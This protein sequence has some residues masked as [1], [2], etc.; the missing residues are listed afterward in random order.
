[1]QHI[2]SPAVRVAAQQR[3]L[4][5]AWLTLLGFF[6]LF[7]ALLAAA[8]FAV[9]NYYLTATKPQTATLFTR[10][11]PEEWL[12]W[13]PASRTKYQGA[14]DQQGLTEGDAVR[15]TSLSGYGQVAS[16]RL[17]DTSQLDLWASADVTLE[18]LRTSRWGQRVQ[19]V[20]L[21]QDGGYVRYDIK[22][23]QP[24]QQVR[25]QVQVGAASVE[26]APGG[27]YSIDMRAPERAVRLLGEAALTADVAVRSGT[28]VVRGANGARAELRAG[29]RL[30]LD[31]AGAPGL[32][33]P[34]RWELIRDGG[35][36]QF[37]EEA[38]NN[39]T[40]LDNPQL[41]RSTTWRVWSSPAL[42]PEQQGFFRLRRICRPPNT[43]DNACREADRRTAAW[44]YRPG[45]QTSGFT[46]G[47]E[48]ELGPDGAGV[49]I[50][51]YRSLTLSLAARVLYQSLA[52]VGDRGTECPVMVRLVAK[53]AQP[54]DPEE[55]RV[56][57]IYSSA[58]GEPRQIESEGVQ[59]E[60]VELAE[61]RQFA[62]DLRDPKWLPDYR[63]I[64]RIQIYA[65]G[66]DYD[67]RVAEVSLVGEQ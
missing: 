26:L 60:R 51:E 57:C 45:S 13:K 10:G 50:S 3:T 48:Q 34:A 59:Y 52:D 43:R 25:F 39:T 17:F 30:E 66:H 22:T 5:L 24:Y 65:N 19:E 63:Y 12:S 37:S 11:A 54:S 58:T 55:E 61:W 44:F 36:S 8:G 62:F 38:Y 40:V 35:F 42:P 2:E 56:V 53:R 18:S 33:V 27:S 1:M 32:A 15:V 16:I 20:M 47:I 67:S 7:V 4:R 31:P 41:L 23:D 29:E 14:S 6:L 49:D 28:A 21:R 64:Q 9:R 46:T